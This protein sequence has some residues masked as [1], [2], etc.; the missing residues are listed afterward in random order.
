MVENLYALQTA[1]THIVIVELDIY[2]PPTDLLFIPHPPWRKIFQFPPPP[3]F[4]TGRH[5]VFNVRVTIRKRIAS[6]PSSTLSGFNAHPM[7]P[8]AIPTQE[9]LSAKES[10]EDPAISDTALCC[11]ILNLLASCVL[12]VD[13]HDT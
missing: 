7:P 12:K 5:I 10:G 9:S 1:K 2:I 4:N 8:K 11:N 13:P 6:S 3:P